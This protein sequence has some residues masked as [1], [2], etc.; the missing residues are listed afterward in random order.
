MRSLLFLLCFV[1]VLPFGAAA[2]AEPKSDFL[3]FQAW[4]PGYKDWSHIRQ[5][6][7]YL[8]PQKDPHPYQWQGYGW[9]AE[10]W[11][12]QSRNGESLVRGFY[13]ADIL[14]DQDVEDGV[15]VLVVGP[16][17]YRLGGLD[18]RRVITTVDTVYGVTR[19][20][21]N[22]AIVL[23]DWHTDLQIGVYTEH[24]LQIQ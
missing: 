8:E 6:Q 19:D 12:A 9:Y 24:G 5:T 17:F 22:R 13:E 18:K 23:K 2:L 14:R 11:L 7:P 16:S 4:P 3:L 1:S 10:D 15:P 20:G 21:Q